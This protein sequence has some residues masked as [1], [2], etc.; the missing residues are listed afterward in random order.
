MPVP[1]PTAVRAAAGRIPGPVLLIASSTL[2][3][4]GAAA[5]VG[6]FGTLGAAGTTW[7]RLACAA[8]LLAAVVRP[9]LR[10]RSGRDLGAVALLGLASA[11][12][13]FCFSLALERLPL[14]VVVTLSFV[15]PLAI[16]VAASRRLPD[17]LWVALAA[18][19]VWL[20]AGG[21]GSGLDPV[22]LLF[23]AGNA[24]GWAAYILLTR[25]VGSAWSG[26]SGLSCSFV[27]AAAATAPFAAPA[28]LTRLDAAVLAA[29]IGLALLVP[30]LPY[31]LELV[32]LR[33]VPPRLFGV[34]MAMEPAIG[35]VFG[36][37]L[38]GQL[39]TA[40]Q[41]VA[42]GLVTAASAGATLAARRTG[43]A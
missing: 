11:A 7:L 18:A 16:A 32:A 42:I 34:L 14:G 27:V 22:G 9:R 13:T 26:L 40:A 4:V 1:S 21:V 25:R 43:R 41:V 8:V 33:T 6:L 15:G 38:L 17:L 39:L 37:V 3:Q 31:A 29:G 12:N 24:A 19:G 35:A 5:S 20:L 23:S 30:L 2:V 28:V 36:L 10:G